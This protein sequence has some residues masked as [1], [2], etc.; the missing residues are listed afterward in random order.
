MEFAE[1]SSS[2]TECLCW[3]KN[4]AIKNAYVWQQTLDPQTGKVI[5][6]PTLV[7]LRINKAATHVRWSLNENK[8]AVAS[9]HRPDIFVTCRAET[10]PSPQV[11]PSNSPTISPSSSAGVEEESKPISSSATTEH[12]RIVFARNSSGAAGQ[13]S[14]I[15]INSDAAS[16]PL[17]DTILALKSCGPESISV[18]A[19]FPDFVAESFALLRSGAARLSSHPPTAGI[20][21]AVC[22][23]FLS[24]CR[25]KLENR[26]GTIESSYDLSKLLDWAPTEHEKDRTASTPVIIK[27]PTLRY[28]LA[29]AE[30]HVEGEEPVVFDADN[31]HSWWKALVFCLS[32]LKTGLVNKDMKFVY[33]ESVALHDLV[34]KVPV[35]LW[36]MSSLGD[37]LQACREKALKHR[38]DDDIKE[39][40]GIDESLPEEGRLNTAVP[41]C[42]VFKRAVD[43]VCAWTTGPTHLLRSKIVRLP[44]VASVSILDLPSAPISAIS[45]KDLIE[46][47]SKTARWSSEKLKQATSAIQSSRARD[48][49]RAKAAWHCEAGLMASLLLRSNP[50]LSPVDKPAVVSRAFQNLQCLTSPIIIGVAKKCCPVCRMLSESLRSRYQLSIEL[51][52]QHSRYFP[53]VP[54]HWLPM[55]ILQDIEARLLQVVTSMLMDGEHLYP[56]FVMRG[57]VEDEL[58]SQTVNKNWNPARTLGV[59]VS[60]SAV[61]LGRVVQLVV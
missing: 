51:P 58:R 33:K 15:N 27:S 56:E 61:G 43:A 32:A 25:T 57:R 53:W 20:R 10:N 26:L 45:Y 28:S 42:A 1:C 6:K 34:Q 16:L 7:P 29:V 22:L 39:E 12:E 60:A 36:A 19:E 2:Q 5:W 3:E 18:P 38:N 31:V 37:H 8:F 14:F 46:Y 24:A 9:G 4:T 59:L 23:Y 48:V 11:S 55:D 30:V 49:D 44:I 13:H 54:P 41:E 17:L 50:D 40:D 47:W 35:T 21:E 52:G